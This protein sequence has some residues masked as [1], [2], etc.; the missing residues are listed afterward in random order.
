MA[1][2]V[3][4]ANSPEHAE[5]IKKTIESAVPILFGAVEVSLEQ[6]IT[7]LGKIIEEEEEKSRERMRIK[8]S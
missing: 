1:R 7:T 6:P 3:I 4:R 8:L 5:A 2:V